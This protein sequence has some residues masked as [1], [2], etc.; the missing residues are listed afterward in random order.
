MSQMVEE[1]Q[2]VIV[3]AGPAGLTLGLCLAQNGITVRFHPSL[4]KFQRL[5]YCTVNYC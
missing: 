4:F 2:V 5:I 3:G 1:T